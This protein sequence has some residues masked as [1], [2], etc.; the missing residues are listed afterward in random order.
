M[1]YL[2][3][4][5]AVN[6]IQF[7]VDQ[8]MIDEAKLSKANGAANAR[9]KLSSVGQSR[10]FQSI[11][12]VN[13]SMQKLAVSPIP[14]PAPIHGD[15]APTPMA[16]SAPNGDITFEEAK[17]RQEEQAE[18][19]LQCSIDNKEGESKLIALSF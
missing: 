3:T 10:P 4:R 15:V 13:G 17:R 9:A 19:A 12:S 8:K 16:D 18:A 2:R 6:A 1:Y 7:T 11:D 14:S 5:P